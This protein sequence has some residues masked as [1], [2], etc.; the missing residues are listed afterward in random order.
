METNADG[1]K[2][3][4]SAT[5]AVSILVVCVLIGT[6]HLQPRLVLLTR[7]DAD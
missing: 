3:K 4:V 6:G 5:T 7:G 2:C 1:R